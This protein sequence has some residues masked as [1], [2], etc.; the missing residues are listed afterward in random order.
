M[1]LPVTKVGGI[2]SDSSSNAKNPQQQVATVYPNKHSNEFE[3]T[4]MMSRISTRT[5]NPVSFS[6]MWK[7]YKEV[8][9]LS[10]YYMPDTI[11]PYDMKV[12]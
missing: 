10:Y 1:F 5:D 11:K 7:N 8:F 3:Y 2:T 4:S 6:G 12:G 9:G